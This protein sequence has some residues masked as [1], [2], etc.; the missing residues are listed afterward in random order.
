[1]SGVREGNEEK[2][3]AARKE[4]ARADLEEEQSERTSKVEE[5][6]LSWVFPDS[7]QRQTHSPIRYT[8]YPLLTMEEATLDG[9]GG[10]DALLNAFE[11]DAPETDV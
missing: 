8:E 7:Q 5:E 10:P 4:E 11:G 3:R 1:M 6:S 2:K 9:H